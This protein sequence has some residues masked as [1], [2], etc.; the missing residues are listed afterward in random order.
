[1]LSATQA[2][3]ELC[4]KVHVFKAWSTIREDREVLNAY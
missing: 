2:M 1:M 3:D 4:S